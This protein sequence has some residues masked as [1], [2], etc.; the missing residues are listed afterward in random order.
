MG[1]TSI[2]ACKICPAGFYCP[3]SGLV[4]PVPCPDGF[5]CPPG[6][7]SLGQAN[8]PCPIGHFC[9]GGSK[10]RKCP[11]G[12]YQVK[13]SK[14]RRWVW[15]T[16]LKITKYQYTVYFRMRRLRLTAKIVR[17][18]S[19]AKKVHSNL[20]RVDLGHFQTSKILLGTANVNGAGPECTVTNLV[21]TSPLVN[22]PGSV[23]QTI[24]PFETN[25]TIITIIPVQVYLYRWIKNALGISI[26]T[27]YIMY[28]KHI[29]QRYQRLLLS[30]GNKISLKTS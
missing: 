8:V 16:L 26:Y 2:L 3:K 19:G 27:V 28:V 7:K 22:V 14:N 12:S 5:V 10:K 18:V 23:S 29:G 21:S 11:A 15:V 1:A 13:C 25:R 24:E 20:F 4:N 6:T 17:L 30:Q 9:R